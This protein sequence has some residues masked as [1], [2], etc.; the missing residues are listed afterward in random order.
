[1]VGMPVGDCIRENNSRR[2]LSDGLDNL[3]LMRFVINEEAV[4]EAEIVAHSNTLNSRCFC[5]FF[6]SGLS[7]TAGTQFAARKIDYTYFIPFGY[8]F[9]NGT[10]AS[11]FGIIG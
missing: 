1:M 11:E 2:V 9:S 7:C 8:V 4:A 3:E 10:A 5:C 6:K